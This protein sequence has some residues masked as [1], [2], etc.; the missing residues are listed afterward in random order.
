[1]AMVIERALGCPVVD[2][3]SG[4]VLGQGLQVTTVLG[5]SRFTDD[6]DVLLRHR[7]LPHPGG[8]EGLFAGCVLAAPR[9]LS[10]T[11]RVHDGE[12]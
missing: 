1:M 3:S 5:R 2:S 7:L 6:L 10:V 12:G 11:N 9:D 8:F 4:P